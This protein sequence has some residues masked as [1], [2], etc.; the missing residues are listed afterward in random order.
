MVEICGG[1]AAE[2]L[3]DVARAKPKDTKITLTQER[4]RRVDR[5]RA[6]ARAGA[7][8]PRGPRV[9]LPL[10]AAGPLHRPC[11]LLADGRLDTGRRR[12]GSGAHRR[13][14]RAAD[15]PASRRDPAL[16]ARSAYER[17]ESGA[18]E[19]LAASGLQEVIT[20]SLTDLPTLRKVLPPEELA[21]TP[22]LH[23]A[24]PMSHELRVRAND[25]ARLNAGDACKN[26][27]LAGGRL[28]SLYEI[29]R[30]YLPRDERL[31]SRDG[32]SL[33][34]DFR[35]KARPMGAAFG[36]SGRVLR[37]EGAA[38]PSPRSHSAS[39]PSTGSRWISRIF[40]VVQRRYW[41]MVAVAHWSARCIPASLQA[42][43][44][45]QDV[46]MVEVDLEAL[47]PHV[48][49]SGALRVGLTLSLR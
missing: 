19:I 49:E 47:L 25:A 12:G 9:R 46:A 4:L 30:V 29:A 35:T 21:T 37:G 18:R 15:D 5:H 38:R 13:L 8:G 39:Q 42:F 43:D 36:R 7:P 23:I 3:L 11:P 48:P 41:S 24:N 2:G 27:R 33:R 44:I 32:I 40:P 34:R 10:G 22:P 14:R 17:S 1:R 45:T 16:G 28:V 6:A 31:T 26:L 20:Y